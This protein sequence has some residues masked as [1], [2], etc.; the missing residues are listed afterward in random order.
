V[1]AFAEWLYGTDPSVAIHSTLWVIRSLQAVHLLTAGVVAGSGIMIALR[2]MGWQRADEPFE[3]VWKR[4]APWLGWGTAVMVSTGFAQ[5]L[6]DP[7]RELTATSYWVKL[8]LVLACAVGTPA[9]A[10]AA[11]HASG[12]VEISAPAKLMAAAL[13]VSWLAIVLLGRM[14]GYDLAIWGSLSL[15][16]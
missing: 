1:R 12:A 7:V 9:L 10:R 16:T 15:R 11:R 8:A 5:T 2:A 3:A 4:F 6:G 13:I 14:I